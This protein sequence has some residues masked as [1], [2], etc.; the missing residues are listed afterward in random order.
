ELN[1]LATTFLK[2]PG[3]HLID[4]ISTGAGQ[5]QSANVACP[6]DQRGILAGECGPG[7]F[8]TAKTLGKGDHNNFGP[9]V[10]FAWDV[11]GNGK[12]S[13]RGGFGVSY[14]GTLYNPLSNTR[15]NP[16]YYSFDE[17]TNT[18]GGG[19]SQILYGPVTGGTPT[20][21][22]PSPPG[23]HAGDGVQATGNMSGWDPS[24]PHLAELT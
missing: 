11:L 6:G 2:G 8:A 10:G 12:T 14:E 4:D 13:L 23:Q 5:I 3:Q 20:F 24:N 7:G 9:R 18:L 16:P 15:W 17:A 21:V 1:N 19:T 22:G